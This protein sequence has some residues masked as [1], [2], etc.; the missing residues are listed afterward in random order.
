M[1]YD[2]FLEEKLEESLNPIFNFPGNV[3]GEFYTEIK[4]LLYQVSGIEKSANFGY[5]FY[6]KMHDNPYPFCEDV[7]KTATFTEQ[8]YNLHDKAL[9]SYVRSFLINNHTDPK[10]ILE[11]D[12]IIPEGHGSH[13]FESFEQIEKNRL[14]NPFPVKADLFK[15]LFYA[16]DN[17]EFP[18]TQ[19][20]AACVVGYLNIEKM[21]PVL[22]GKAIALLNM[23]GLDK[24]KIMVLL[25]LVKSVQIISPGSF[26]G[27]FF[28]SVGTMIDSTD[29]DQLFENYNSFKENHRETI[30]NLA[31][32]S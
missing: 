14:K 15:I 3:P 17:N 18:M 1:F 31:D 16:I 10:I 4:H 27:T 8:Y 11:Y 19:K 25:H 20:K 21:I 9:K 7:L 32:F 12:H 5:F 22:I 30:Q 29:N 28:Q 24:D 13:F 26:D 23:P 2:E 6:E